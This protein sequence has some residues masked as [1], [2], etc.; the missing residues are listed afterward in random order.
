[1][2]EPFV[3]AC[4]EKYIENFMV[5]CTYIRNTRAPLPAPAFLSLNKY[6]PAE[7]LCSD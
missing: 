6:S 1:L 4:Q 7:T 2:V 3:F 5:H